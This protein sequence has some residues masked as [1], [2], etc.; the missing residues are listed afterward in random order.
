[1]KK[2]VLSILVVL[3]LSLTTAMAQDFSTSAAMM[4]TGSSYSATVSPIGATTVAF[5][6]TT[7]EDYNPSATRTVGRRSIMGDD[8]YEDTEYNAGDPLPIGSP[9]V[10]L[11]LFAAAA[12]L[13]GTFRRKSQLEA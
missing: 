5:T 4:N 6:T 3:A 7:A 13:V 11:L 9:I 12:A 8:D 2:Y 1:M 10:P